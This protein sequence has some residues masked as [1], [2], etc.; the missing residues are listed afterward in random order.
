MPMTQTISQVAPSLSGWLGASPTSLPKSQITLTAYDQPQLGTDGT[1][2]DLVYIHPQNLRNRVSRTYTMNLE[3][4]ANP[5][6]ISYYTYDIHG[7]VDTVMQDYLGVAG[8]TSSPYKLIC[9]DYDLVSGKVNG[10]DYQPGKPD[11]FYYRYSYDAENRLTDVKT[12]RDSIFW[13]DDARYAYYKHGPLERMVLGKLSV[14]GLDY[15]YTLQGWLKGINIGNGFAGVMPDGSSCPPGSALADVDVSSRPATGG[16]AEYFA[17]NSITFDSG[18]ETFDND[19]IETDFDPSL[20]VSRLP[21]SGSG[22][23]GCSV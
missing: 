17:L 16:P 23:S 20:A 21:G 18:F 6:V 14:Q 4:D 2:I 12:S 22:A 10:V 5:Y 3:S 19:V 15:S 1:P 8:M 9:Y 7:N 11:A 13:E